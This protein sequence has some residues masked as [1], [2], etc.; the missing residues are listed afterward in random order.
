[1]FMM[2]TVMLMVIIMMVVDGDKNDGGRCDNID[3][4]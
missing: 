4:G 1:M 3:G 2:M